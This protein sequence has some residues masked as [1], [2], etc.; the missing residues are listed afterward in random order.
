MRRKTYPAVISVMALIILSA[1]ID[2]SRAAQTTSDFRDFVNP[3]LITWHHVPVPPTNPFA[4][5]PV[6]I[7]RTA[8]GNT[9]FG[10]D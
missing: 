5:G 10:F 6:S 9:F 7:T 4:L 3:Y 1:S 2:C 8:A